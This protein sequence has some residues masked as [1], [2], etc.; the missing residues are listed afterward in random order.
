M[1]QVEKHD[2]T[3]LPLKLALRRRLLHPFAEQ[4]PLLVMDCCAGSGLIWKRL[5]REFAVEL[6]LPF[7]VKRVKGAVRVDSARW[8]RDVGVCGS[9]VDV[10]AYGEPWRQYRAVLAGEWPQSDLLVFLTVGQGVG[11]LGKISRAALQALGMKAE[12][13]QSIPPASQEIRDLIV[14]A[15]LTHGAGEE[16]EFVQAVHASPIGS[17]TRYFGLWLRRPADTTRGAKA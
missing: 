7:D 2:N 15:C 6:Y 17:K 8:L 11:S 10:D 9:V 14:D 12:W 5:R 1:P 13:H 16:I 4:W 3:S